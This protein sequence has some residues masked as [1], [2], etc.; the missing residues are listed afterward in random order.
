MKAYI[1]IDVRTGEIASVIR[2]LDR[3]AAVKVAEM[4]FGAFDAIAIVEA[5][6]L[7]ALGR[8]IALEIQTIP[9]VLDTITCLAVHVE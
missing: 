5:E 7:E 3:V 6:N 9:G 2:H 8:L 4:T 1:L